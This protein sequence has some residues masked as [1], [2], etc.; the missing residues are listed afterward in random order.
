MFRLRRHQSIIIKSIKTEAFL[1][2]W[3]ISF[4][5]FAFFPDLGKMVFLLRF[6]KVRGNKERNRLSTRDNFVIK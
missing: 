3:A 4:P 1:R 6:P 2:E 5:I